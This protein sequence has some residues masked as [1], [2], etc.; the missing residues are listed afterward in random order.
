[1]PYYTVKNKETGVTKLVE[2]DNRAKAFRVVGESLLEVGIA[3][4]DDVAKHLEAGGKIERKIEAQRNIRLD[5]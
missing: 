5:D 1:M 3:S 4:T 2:S